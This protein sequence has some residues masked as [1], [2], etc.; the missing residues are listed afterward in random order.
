MRALGENILY[1]PSGPLEVVVLHRGQEFLLK[2]FLVEDVL[3]CF[4]SFEEFVHY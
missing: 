3:V 1:G 2:V 4:G